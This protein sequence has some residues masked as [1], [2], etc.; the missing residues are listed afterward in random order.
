MGCDPIFIDG[1]AAGFICSRGRRAPRCSEAGCHH[2]AIALCD[3][4]L[5]GRQTGKTCSRGLCAI[6][7][8]AQPANPD[9]SDRDY[10][11]AHDRAAK[12][13]GSLL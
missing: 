8:R 13:Q 2:P 4:P 12:A 5:A 9:G 10:C 1:K 3:W 11:P 6:H 7:R